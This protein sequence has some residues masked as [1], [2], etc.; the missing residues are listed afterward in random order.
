[1]AKRSLG[2]RNKKKRKQPEYDLQLKLVDYVID[3][4]PEVIFNSDSAGIRFSPG[5]L[6]KFNKLKY[7]SKKQG[8]RFAFPDFYMPYEVQGNWYSLSIELKSS[9][10][11]ILTK[12]GKF[13]KNTHLEDQIK[14]LRYIVRQNHYAD[15]AG[16][17]EDAK[18]LVDWYMGLNKNLSIVTTTRP[19]WPKSLIYT[20]KSKI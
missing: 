8:V 16:G 12:K 4:Y 5:L 20:T 17:F 13:I 2:T 19:F 10:D 3:S 11:K 1:M 15:L 18:N 6:S 9:I 14:C 7:G